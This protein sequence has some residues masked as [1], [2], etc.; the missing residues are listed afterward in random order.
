MYDLKVAEIIEKVY[1]IQEV[2]ES[3][4]FEEIETAFSNTEYYVN[5]KTY[6]G[7]FCFSANLLLFEEYYREEI[8]KKQL[9]ET[10]FD[11]LMVA[12]IR[13]RV[14]KEM[15]DFEYFKERLE[16]H[17]QY[18]DKECLLEYAFKLNSDEKDFLASIAKVVYIM[19]IDCAIKMLNTPPSKKN[20]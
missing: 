12:K 5:P 2:D 14:F 10:Y 11:E 9:S 13:F 20:L 17:R 3:V 16:H 15:F 8:E 19:G 6:N 7:A 1:Q 4:S 18:D